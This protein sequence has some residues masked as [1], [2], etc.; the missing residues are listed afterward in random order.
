MGKQRGFTLIELM[1]VIAIIGILASVALPQYNQYTRQAYFIEV[2]SAVNPIKSKVETCFSLNGGAGP[3]N[4]CTASAA[5][6]TVRGQVTSA[7][8]LRAANAEGVTSVSLAGGAQPIITVTP[9]AERGIT[10]ADTYTLT[11]TLSADGAAIVQWDESG[12]ACSNG[13]C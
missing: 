13:Y 5:S 7:D 8:L 6:P 2:K 12:V 1:I 10:A 4:A 9:A 3:G 11:G